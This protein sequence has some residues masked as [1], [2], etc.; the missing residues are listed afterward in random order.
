MPPSFLRNKAS[1]VGQSI[2]MMR[3]GVWVLAPMT[4]DWPN[5]TGAAFTSWPQQAVSHD[6]AGRTG[7]WGFSQPGSSP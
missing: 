3:M 4:T 1:S 7:V 2:C 5:A 6:A